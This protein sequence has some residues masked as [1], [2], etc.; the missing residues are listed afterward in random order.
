[1]TLAPTGGD[2]ASPTGVATP[3][4]RTKRS[5]GIE[6][7]G[8]PRTS[9]SE[10]ASLTTKR[11]G[12]RRCKGFLS[13]NPLNASTVQRRSSSP[14]SAAGP[15]SSTTSRSS[16]EPDSSPGSAGVAIRKESH[17]RSGTQRTSGS[18]PVGNSRP[19]GRKRSW[20]TTSKNRLDGICVRICSTSLSVPLPR[21]HTSSPK[22]PIRTSATLWSLASTLACDRR[23]DRA[24]LGTSYSPRR[25][26]ARNNAKAQRREGA[27]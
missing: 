27:K 17:S 3:A 6:G 23:N 4:W 11:S 9:T 14:E 25:A 10:Q 1:M 19:L 24:Q 13:K 16:A 20:C 22:S 8:F 15:A 2:H 7:S 18:L 12:R 21:A 26:R 5:P